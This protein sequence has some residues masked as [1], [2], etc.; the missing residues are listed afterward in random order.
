V[1]RRE[2]DH[3]CRELRPLRLVNCHCVSQ[4]DSSSSPKSYYTIRS[5]KRIA[6]CCSTGSTRSTIPTSPL[7]TVLVVVVLGL[8]DFVPHLEPPAEPLD[9]KLAGT[10]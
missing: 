6:T 2:R 3:H 10:N 9:A 8:N 1:L 4:R 7:N 5:S